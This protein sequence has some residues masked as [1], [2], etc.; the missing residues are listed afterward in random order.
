MSGTVGPSTGSVADTQAPAPVPTCLLVA[1]V[2]EEAVEP[3]LEALGVAQPRELAP[4]KEERLLDG[5][6][7]PLNVPEDPVRDR[8]AAVAFQV[9]EL[10][11]GALVASRARSTNLS[12]MGS[13]PRR[14]VQGASPPK[15]VPCGERFTTLAERPWRSSCAAGPTGCPLVGHAEPRQR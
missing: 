8:V 15:M 7:C 5:V 13:L 1:G 12:R 14:P 6:L 2:D 4:G 11:E 3:G 10:G 9:D